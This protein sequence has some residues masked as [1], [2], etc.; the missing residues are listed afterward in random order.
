MYVVAA[1]DAESFDRRPNAAMGGPAV[2]R[3]GRQAALQHDGL[4]REPERL[5]GL[6]VDHQLE[7]DWSWTR[8]LLG[9]ATRSPTSRELSATVFA[10]D[11]RGGPPPQ[12]WEGAIYLEPF[13][14]DL[15]ARP[16]GFQER[17]RTLEV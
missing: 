14:H 7:V 12:A 10:R 5:G 8:S 13:E 9:S 1:G 4:H 17:V 3:K 16:S 6:E 2:K 11:G 15:A